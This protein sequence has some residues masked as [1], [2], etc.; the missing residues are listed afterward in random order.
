MARGGH[1][2]VNGGTVESVRSLD[3]MKLARAGYFVD[4]RAQGAWQWS[5][6]SGNQAGIGIAG[7]ADAITLN[8]RKQAVGS[9]DWQEVEQRVPII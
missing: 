7:G 6:A 9:D 5:N 2:R 1:N 8:Y 3:V 4:G